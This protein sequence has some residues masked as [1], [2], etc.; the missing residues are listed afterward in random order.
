MRLGERGLAQILLQSR[1]PKVSNGAMHTRLR[2][3]EITEPA[4]RTRGRWLALSRDRACT[5]S[6][7]TFILTRGARVGV[8]TV[9]L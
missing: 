2:N 6:S 3:N 4:N 8:G 5:L 7:L 9:G 1:L